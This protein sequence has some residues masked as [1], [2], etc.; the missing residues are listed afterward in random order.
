MPKLTFVGHACFLLEEDRKDSLIFDPFLTEN[1]L[2][3][4]KAE[5]VRVRYILVSHGHMDHLGDSYDIAEA[6]NAMIIST[7]EIAS[8][9]QSNGIVAHPMNT[10]GKYNFPFGWVKITLATHAAGPPAYFACGFVVNY[11]GK[12]I[13]F[14]G[15]TGLFGDMKLIGESAPLDVALLPIG[16]NYTMGI[17]DAVIATSFLNP[18]IV[19]PCHYNTMPLVMADPEEFKKK[20]EEKT[21]SK[22]IVIAPGESYNL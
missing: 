7:S 1:P 11:H 4:M 18:K 16:D 20:V 9:A 12:N 8:H 21:N 22:C 14:A 13:Y 10:G 19:I 6:N 17:D 2:T 15:D 5:D 3:N